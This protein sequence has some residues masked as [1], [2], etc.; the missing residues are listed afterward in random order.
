MG[1]AH[2]LVSQ[3]PALDASTKQARLPS[4]L[5][6][7]PGPLVDALA[8]GANTVESAARGLW[9]RDPSVWSDEPAIQRSISNRLGW[10]DSPAVMAASIGAHRLEPRDGGRRRIATRNELGSSHLA[11]TAHGGRGPCRPR[12]VDPDCSPPELDAFGLWVEQLIAKST[13]KQGTGIVPIS[14][15]AVTYEGWPQGRVD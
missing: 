14:G 13:G 7:S 5:R 3:W 9:R 15:D 8:A 10:L 2:H 12:H 4:T 6:I 1:V 11:W